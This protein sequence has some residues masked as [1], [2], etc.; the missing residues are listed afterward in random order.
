MAIIALD[1]P[2]A[3]NALNKQMAGELAK[4]FAATHHDRHLRAIVLTGKGEKAFC[5]GADLKE[6]KGMDEAAWHAQHRAF[7]AALQGILDCPVPV[8]AAVGGAAFGGGLE[9][10][11]ACDFIYAS[12]N[13]KFALTEATLGIMPGLG[14]TTQL[15]RA[16]G[17]RRAKELLYTGRAF[18][19]Q[20]AKEWGMVNKI[21]DISELM[22]ESVAA[23]E[24][25]AE[26]APLAIRAIKQSSRETD[27]LP[28]AQALATELRHYN[29]LL[30]TA[31]RVE[32]IN[33]FNEKRKAEFVGN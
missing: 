6:R 22:T 19:A 33:A 32:G 16:V 27:S 7:E 11:L 20:E 25:I 4:I 2:E 1:R 3:A 28:L 30:T 14:G 18:S 26:N 13:A 12:H 5:A 21:V 31:D 23:A 8:I 15:S 17:A 24:K 10:A 29:R 9:L